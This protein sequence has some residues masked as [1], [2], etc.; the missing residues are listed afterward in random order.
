MNYHH[1][2]NPFADVDSLQDSGYRIFLE[3]PFRV[4]KCRDVL[5]G[6]F[7]VDADCVLSIMIATIAVTN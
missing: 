1:D 2:S 3:K 7:T 5:H 4:K 6:V